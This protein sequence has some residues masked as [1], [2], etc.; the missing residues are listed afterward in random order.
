MMDSQYHPTKRPISLQQARSEFYENKNAYPVFKRELYDINFH[1]RYN[2]VFSQNRSHL[3]KHQA[4]SG[5]MEK[6]WNPAKYIPH[7]II[8]GTVLKDSIQE[9]SS[10]ASFIRIS[11]QKSFLFPPAQNCCSRRGFYR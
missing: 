10:E 8:K 3:D 2:E 4:W 7:A 1:I 11:L 9:T 6:A 5:V